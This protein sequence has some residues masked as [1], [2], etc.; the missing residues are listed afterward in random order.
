MK[1]LI[2]DK[3]K[4][5]LL[6]PVV[7]SLGCGETLAP[8]TASHFDP[9]KPCQ[10]YT[11]PQECAA[12]DSCTYLQPRS[13]NSGA[14]GA[15]FYK[16]EVG[17][18]DCSE[19][20]EKYCE[21]AGIASKEC[22][23]IGRLCQSASD[24][25]AKGFSVKNKYHKNGTLRDDQGFDFDGFDTK[26]FDAAH[27]Y[28][29]TNTPYDYLG[30]D[31]QGY[32]DRGFNADHNH[33]DTNGPY[34]NQGF[35]YRGY[36]AQG[37]DAAHNHRYTNGPYDDQ[38]FDYQ[39]YNDRGFDAAHNHR[40]TNGQYDNQGFDFEGY[41]AR[42]FSELRIHRDT[43]TRYDAQGFDFEGYDIR[44]FNVTHNH[45][46]T[47]G[48]QDNDGYDY[49]GYDAR[50]F[51]RFGN[52]RLGG[53][54]D[55]YGFDR[56]AVHRV[57]G[58]NFDENGFDF[59]GTHPATGT[60]RNAFGFNREGL[61]TNGSLRD[62]Q[63]FD[64]R[65]FNVRGFDREGAF[66]DGTN[67]DSH[68][69]D[70]N[71]IH[72]ETGTP[73]NPA[74]FN[75]DGIHNVTGDRFDAAAPAGVNIDGETRVEVRQK[76]V[77]ERCYI[78]GPADAFGR[79]DLRSGIVQIPAGFADAEAFIRAIEDACSQ[80]DNS[81]KFNNAAQ[82]RE[83]LIRGLRANLGFGNETESYRHVDRDH[84]LKRYIEHVDGPDAG[85]KVDGVSYL[86]EFGADAGGLTKDFR[87]Q[88]SAKMLPLFKDK[89]DGVF[90]DEAFN[91]FQQCVAVG[92]APTAQN[93][94]TNVGRA[95]AKL[96]F[97]EG[98]TFGFGGANNYAF[99]GVP[100][101]K[102]SSA[103]YFSLLNIQAANAAEQFAML[104]I[105]DPVFFNNALLTLKMDDDDI[106]DLEMEMADGTVV[107]ANNLFAYFAEN[108][109]GKL[110]SQELGWLSNGFR[111]FVPALANIDTTAKLRLI[112]QGASVDPN[113]LIG[114]IGPVFDA[115][116]VQIKTWL[117]EIIREETG[118]EP[119]DPEF[120]PKLLRFWTGSSALPEQLSISFPMHF[121]AASLPASHTC[122]NMLDL[123]IYP[124]KAT[125]RQK[126]L[127]SLEH[128]GGFGNG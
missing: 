77:G 79:Q 10:L 19:F 18:K 14:T 83:N 82:E 39:G 110:V 15:C 29:Y 112:M 104:K 61:H 127:L 62:N 40:D 118:N 33:R 5:L 53:D 63:G 92:Q 1:I 20:T 88:V 80:W 74:G 91:D 95:M 37:F 108:L 34:D 116:Q 52:H 122:S 105:L 56:H 4:F 49:Q 17:Q 121:N 128:G 96:S 102:L 111:A 78:P 113:D 109:Q 89:D 72:R 87:E 59:T 119:R 54:Y 43:F 8:S 30:F 70:V 23:Y 93:C 66:N 115:E 81:K 123:A 126:L 60:D 36:N 13:N 38:G 26:G 32:N 68:G 125:M 11:N 12:Q 69:F 124:D 94:W 97:I 75:F 47:N 46:D 117:E 99:A 55:E 7:I 76:E 86:N 103:V 9:P 73:H 24:F 28:R 90:P 22:F 3:I 35:D 67:Y 57:T 107:D 6:F 16:S 2:F 71:G 101:L 84:I 100:H 85:K 41:D 58:N 48:P 114:K 65:G 98:G 31:Y 50:G 45:R 51:N 42:G 106:A 27:N 120:L 64:I 21:L 25:N 44:G